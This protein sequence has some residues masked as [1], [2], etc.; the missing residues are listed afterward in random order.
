MYWTECSVT[1]AC[2]QR[3]ISIQK[4]SARDVRCNTQKNN[5]SFKYTPSH[6]HIMWFYTIF[7]YFFGV[8]RNIDPI[9][10]PV[11]QQLMI[12]CFSIGISL[13][14]TAWDFFPLSITLS[15]SRKTD[16]FVANNIKKLSLDRMARTYQL[17]VPFSD[18]QWFSTGRDWKYI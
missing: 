3:C 10:S 4:I 14:I 15:V 13:S 8:N 5:F 12:L 16:N 9:K 17:D 1:S 6:S 18:Q 7:I 11:K 2:Q